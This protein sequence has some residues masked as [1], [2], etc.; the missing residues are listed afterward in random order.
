[1]KTDMKK[2][3][4][5]KTGMKKGKKVKTGMK[6]GYCKSKRVPPANELTST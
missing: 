2:G 3:K 6:K 4:K 5:V 1:M